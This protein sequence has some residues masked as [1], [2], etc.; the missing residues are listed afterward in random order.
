[1]KKI[2]FFIAIVLI[3]GICLSSCNSTNNDLTQG[4]TGEQTK[5]HESDKIEVKE[6]FLSKSELCLG[7]GE[8]SILIATKSPSNAPGELIWSS[9]N[10]EIAS[11]DNSGNVTGV[12]EGETVIKVEADN[13]IVAVCNVTVK[14]KTG[15][16]TGNITYKYNNYVGNKPDTGADVLLISAKV[17]SIPD[18][19]VVGMYIG[20]DENDGIYVTNVDG[21]GTYTLENIPVGEYYIVVVSANTSNFSRGSWYDWGL[22]VYNMLSDEGKKSA[23]IFAQTN[24]VESS[25]ITIEEN[26]TIT[27]SYDFGVSS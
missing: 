6:I 8:S 3:C 10:P 13:G 23:D 2:V 7:L 20:I 4:N 16:I 17:T 12:T 5:V 26:K 21:T 11:V 14:Q 27:F 24:K 18:Q 25:K 19:V 22:E 1:M 9:Q 15:S